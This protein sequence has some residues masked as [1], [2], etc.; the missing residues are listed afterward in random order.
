[1]G[2]YTCVVENNAGRLESAASLVVVVKPLVQ[3]LYNKTYPLEERGA[4]LV[5]K[6]SGSPLPRI[7][8]RKWSR[9]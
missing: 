7:V 5:C 1:V 9:K 3:E 2:E 6:A 8:W 4:T